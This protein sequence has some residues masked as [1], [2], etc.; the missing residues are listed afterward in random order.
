MR[1]YLIIENNNFYIY[2]S[3]YFI[4]PSLPINDYPLIERIVNWK[5]EWCLQDCDPPIHGEK[6]MTA[7]KLQYDSFQ[8]Y[9]R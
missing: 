5:Q 1:F 3:F 7:M 8:E 9:S 4:D 2:I 6:L